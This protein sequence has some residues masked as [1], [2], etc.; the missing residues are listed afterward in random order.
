MSDFL[1]KIQLIKDITIQLP[2]S[3]KDF[4]EKFRNNVDESDFSFVPFEVFQSSRNEYKGNIDG[5]A[6]EL[7]KRRRLFDTNYSF[8]K[9]TGSLIE[10]NDKLIIDAEIL[11]FRKIMILFFGFTIFFYLIAF[12]GMMF[13]NN[14][15]PFFALTFL[16]IHM[17]LVLGIPYFVIRRSVNR[18]AYDLERDFHYWATKN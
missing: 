5:S 2:I 12:T 18:M 13:G 3:K 4:T 6:F 10:R 14:N 8:A 1:R 17:S 16:L 9:V 7:K 11:G 15:I